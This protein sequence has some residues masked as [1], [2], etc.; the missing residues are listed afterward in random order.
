MATCALVGIGTVGTCPS[1][2]GGIVRSFG[3]KL[4]DITSITLTSGVVSAITT[5]AVAA[6]FAQYNYDRDATANFNSTGSLNANRV[7]YEQTAFLKFGGVTD[8]SILAAENADACCET[9]WIHVM[10]N[11]T[12]IVQ[13]I[14]RLAA[15]GAPEGTYNRATRIIST[16][17]TDTTAN[18]NRIEFTIS[19]NS[20]T[21]PMTT[22]MT[23]AEILAVGA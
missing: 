8:A 16:V 23:D 10:A 7:S 21:H 18:E 19:G 11:G 2:Q 20:N 14:E 3:C 5:G 1:N 9:F 13:G 17:N 6:I 15:T 12:R 4:S 22:D